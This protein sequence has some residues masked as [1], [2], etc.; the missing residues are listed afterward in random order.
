VSWDPGIRRRVQDGLS[1]GPD[2]EDEFDAVIGLLGMIAVIT[3]VIPSGEP[4]DDPAVTSIEG[5]IL[6]RPADR[7][8]SPGSPPPQ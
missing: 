8:T 1:P 2:G 6:G 3:G 7:G 5:W 4:G